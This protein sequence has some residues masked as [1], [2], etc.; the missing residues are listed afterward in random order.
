M[1]EILDHVRFEFYIRKKD[2]HVL[3]EKFHIAVPTAFHQDESLNIES[4]IAHIKRL[5]NE[6]ITSVLVSGSTGEQH[7][8][9][10]SEKLELINRLNAEETLLNEMEILFG[11]AA[12]RQK[13]AEKIAIKI[14]DT[15]LA[16][17]LLGFPP[18]VL[19]TQEE[20]LTYAKTI[21]HLSQKPTIIYNNPK[22]TG[23]DLSIESIVELSKHELVIGI[24]EA[25]AK[26]KVDQL[27]RKIKRKDFY[28]YAGGE[29]ELA[30]KIALGYNRISSIAGNIAPQMI[31]Q[32]FFDLLEQNAIDP[33]TQEE[34]Q[35]ILHQVYQGSPL[36][37]I[38][39]YLNGMGLDM[40]ICRSP[41][42]NTEI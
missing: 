21:I 30:E 37:N 28:Y 33:R 32:W 9:S 29:Q 34:I 18:Y 5:Q 10:M 14:S 27:K 38:K 23:F 2:L 6:G 4:T 35:S 3:R 16:G 24:K 36:V 40:G 11:V 20:A 19:P 12:V 25:G 1:W 22:R 31:R 7:S 15:N 39:N 26:E 8:L 41:L 42:G 13:E 17:I